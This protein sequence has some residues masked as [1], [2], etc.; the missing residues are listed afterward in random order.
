MQGVIVEEWADQTE[1]QA[2]KRDLQ[3]VPALEGPKLLTR[4]WCGKY[5]ISEEMFSADVVGAKAMNVTN[6]KVRNYSMTSLLISL[7]LSQLKALHTAFFSMRSWTSNLLS[8]HSRHGTHSIT[9]V[10]LLQGSLPDWV[11]IPKSVALPFGTFEAVL[12]D[13]VNADIQKEVEKLHGKE[14]KKSITSIVETLSP[15]SKLVEE[16]IV[17]LGEQDNKLVL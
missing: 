1:L 12:N 7:L 4:Q 14:D 3:A 11:M 2:L 15:T 5:F 8:R 17:A 13:P 10:I 16:A 9:E 6:I